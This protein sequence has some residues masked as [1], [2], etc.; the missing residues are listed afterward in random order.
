MPRT[1]RRIV[2]KGYY[3]T[4][5]VTKLLG[6]SKTTLYS[7]VRDGRLEQRIPPGAKQ[8]VFLKKQV[9]ELARGLRR[10]SASPMPTAIFTKAIPDDMDEAAKLIDRLFNHW[11]NVERW[12]EYVRRNPDI[13][14]LLKTDTGAVVGCAF[15]MPLPLARIQ[16]HYSMEEATTPSILPEEIEPYTPGKS[17]QVYVRAV[18]ILPGLSRE[19][20][21][22]YGARLLTG[23]IAAF[24]D[25]AT[26]GIEIQAIWAR[27][28]THDGIRLLRKL[29]FTEIESST[30][31]RNFVIRV[32]ES[33][34]P[35]IV[36]YKQTL[37]RWKEEQEH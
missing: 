11:P 7:Y 21:R 8:G 12:R 19:E 31:S 37:A 13:G 20:K 22:T 17:Y 28:R 6:I 5:Q 33:G 32:P 26:R 36:R 10:F 16:E 35:E 25:L 15:L 24:L 34:I 1:Y 29:G 18:G 23:L 2:P 14:F 9:D 27:S 4:G 30:S 3:S